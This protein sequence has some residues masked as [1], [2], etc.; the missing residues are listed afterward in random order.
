MYKKI[1]VPTDGSEFAKK[2][3]KQALFLANADTSFN[4][5]ARLAEYFGITNYKGTASQNI[6]LIEYLYNYS[7]GLHANDNQN[8][9]PE[10]TENNI[11]ELGKT[12]SGVENSVQNALETIQNNRK[13][14]K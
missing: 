13:E 1:L 14:L 2:A 10:E 9:I 8:I 6:L 12:L 3:Q 4:Y 11:I 5:R 7:L